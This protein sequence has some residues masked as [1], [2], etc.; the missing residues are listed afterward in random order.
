MIFF[1]I[2]AIDVQ[3]GG[4]KKLNSQNYKKEIIYFS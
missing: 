3:T 2:F 1:L 4:D